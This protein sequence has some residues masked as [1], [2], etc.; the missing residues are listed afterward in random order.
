MARGNDPGKDF[1]NQWNTSR[2]EAEKKAARG[3]THWAEDKYLK[4]LQEQSGP[5]AHHA[6]QSK[7]CADK[8]VALLALLGGFF[9]A[10]GEIAS[11]VA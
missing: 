10:L 11:R 6:G 1:D 7:G 4:R 8:T 3:E 9:W 2:R 5:P